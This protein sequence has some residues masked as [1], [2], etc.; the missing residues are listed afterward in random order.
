VPNLILIKHSLPEIIPDRPA[1]EWQL[2]DEGRHRCESLAEAVARYQPQAVVTSLE[3]KAAETGQILAAA[4]HLPVASAP[5]LHEHER[6]NTPF[7]SPEMFEA[8]ILAFFAEPSQRVSGTE[9]A[10]ESHDR[11]AQAIWEVVAAHPQQNIAIVAHG[12][13]ISLFVSRLTN[14]DPFLLWKRLGL[15]SFVVIS[16]PEKQLITVENPST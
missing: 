12:T 15:P 11:F 13:V 4:L 16:L 7:L 10:N 6:Q 2:S 8:S 3:P 9:S 5:N 14:A 1:R